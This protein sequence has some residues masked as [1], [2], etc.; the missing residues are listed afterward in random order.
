MRARETDEQATFNDILLRVAG[1]ALIMLMV[2]SLVWFLM[3]VS[4]VGQ[5]PFRVM[6]VYGLFVFTAVLISRI[7]IEISRERAFIYGLAL[8]V[9]MLIAANFFLQIEGPLAPLSFV[10][11]AATIALIWFSASRL[12]WDITVNDD[13]RDASA[14]GL[15]ELFRRKVQSGV[16][17]VVQAAE[18]S[19]Q[20]AGT[21]STATSERKYSTQDG[22]SSSTTE[23][24]LTNATWDQKLREFWPFKKNKNTP[25]LWIFYFSLMAFPIFG[26]GQMM[27]S[28]R[29]L[30]ARRWAFYLFIVYILAAL[31]LLM[32]TSLLGLQRY[33]RQRNVVMPDSMSRSWMLIGAVFGIAVLGLVW[34]LPRPAPEHSVAHV[35]PRFDTPW[36]QTSD[37]AMGNDGDQQS[38]TRAN[39]TE[40]SDDAQQTQSRQGAKNGGGEAGGGKKSSGGGEN[41][42]GDDGGSKTSERKNGGKSSSNPDTQAGN[43]SGDK[44]QGN[45]PQG[46]G[47]NP[48]ESS[49]S[50]SSEDTSSGDTSANKDGKSGSDAREGQPDRGDSQQPPNGKDSSPTEGDKERAGLGSAFK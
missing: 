6:W 44:G 1:P 38:D 2:G 21:D 22:E 48:N 35:L 10:I 24:D 43:K 7:S 40:T 13:S 5:W 30:P 8:A 9:A 26:L 15:V 31:G 3:H 14:Q 17:T 23:R 39:R 37:W 18:A 4:Y 27:L 28:T 42:Q 12:T 41:Q 25:G 50:K 19:Q 29:D 45:D 46:G 33:L 47:E 11:N 34:L 36:R 49:G 16:D 20:P 32:M